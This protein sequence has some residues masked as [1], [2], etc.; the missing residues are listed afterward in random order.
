MSGFSHFSSS[1]H[2]DYRFGFNG[3]EKDDEV[4]NGNGN[5]Y[6]TPFRQL[7]VRLGGRWWSRDPIVKPW[8]SPYVG[9][10]NNPIALSDP[11]G[12][13]P[14]DP[15]K[16]G[17]EQG[18]KGSTAP[19]GG[20]RTGEGGVKGGENVCKFCG[21][22]GEDIYGI[23]EANGSSEPSST[24]PPAEESAGTTPERVIEKAKGYVKQ[25][26]D[27]IRSN[28]Y[29]VEIGG[30]VDVGV[31]AKIKPNLGGLRGEANVNLV[32]YELLAGKVDLTE[33]FSDNPDKWDLDYIG[34]GDGMK[35]SQSLTLTGGLG[36]K[37]YVGAKISHT[38]QTHG[39]GSFDEKVDYGVYAIVPLL[40]PKKN[41][42]VET[43]V[44]RQIAKNMGLDSDPSLQQP[45]VG[46]SGEFKGIT[47]G[48][49]GAL[50]L[51]GNASLKIGW[52]GPKTEEQ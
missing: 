32:S 39:T 19:N 13:D 6:T 50:I 1:E 27:W 29:V 42:S 5:S 15:Y 28:N 43:D 16:K 51:G 11:S 33:L 2:A 30:N 45:K 18:K 20:K 31:Q 14:G 52:V 23:P 40:T 38:F 26:Y 41:K 37:D 22:N 35:V 4:L 7:D 21:E 36:E 3:M 34:D 10:G 24:T 46:T 8:E 9:F 12:L 49:G 47:L 17:D 44:N 48:F 25:V